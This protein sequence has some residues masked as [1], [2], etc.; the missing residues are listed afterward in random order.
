MKTMLCEQPRP[1]KRSDSK[2]FFLIYTPL[3]YKRVISSYFIP[4]CTRNG[5]ECAVRH[6]NG[7]ICTLVPPKRSDRKKFFLIYSL[8]VFK[9]EFCIFLLLKLT[10]TFSECLVRNKNNIFV[11]PALVI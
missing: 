10:C 5:P 8:L 1:L 6:E 4:N 7:D 2:K 3:G 9:I 11:T